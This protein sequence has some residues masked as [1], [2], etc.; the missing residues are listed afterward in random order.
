MTAFEV[1]AFIAA[2]P[3]QVWAILTDGRRLV[4]G[5][6]GVLRVDGV[7]APGRKIRLW[8]EAS[9]SRPFDLK[10]C[11]FDPPRTM[12]WEGGMPFGLFKG[13]RTFTLQAENG[14]VRFQMH[15]AFSGPLAP[16]IVKSIPD[17]TPSFRKFA[18]GLKKLTEETA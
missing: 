2:D 18:A 7:I 10:V 8:S 5:D 4:A 17:L 16:M 1:D 13:V 12:T 3:A 9:P 11:V 15:E 6:L 14:G